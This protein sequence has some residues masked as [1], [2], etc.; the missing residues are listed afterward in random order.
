MVLTKQVVSNAFVFGAFLPNYP[1]SL[2]ING[3]FTETVFHFVYIV[4]ND[5]VSTAFMISTFLKG[6]KEHS[7]VYLFSLALSRSTN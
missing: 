4:Q 5:D 7:L 1:I 2:G 6:K 3:R